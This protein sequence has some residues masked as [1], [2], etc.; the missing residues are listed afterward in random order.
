VRRS[1]RAVVVVVTIGAVIALAGCG[2]KSTSGSSLSAATSPPSTSP[3]PTSMKVATARWWSVNFADFDTLQSDLGIFSSDAKAGNAGAVSADCSQLAVV[4]QSLQKMQTLPPA[5]DK[6]VST[7]F[8]AGLADYARG[9]SDCTHG[10]DNLKD[11]PSM[12]SRATKEFNRAT[13]EMTQAT[14][15]IKALTGSIGVAA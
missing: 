4:T 9:V 6:S 7:P 3:I 11:Y 2:S 5:P 14:G 15:R 13:G 10:T 8:D 12:I 1:G